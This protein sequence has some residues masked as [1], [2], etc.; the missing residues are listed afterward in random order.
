[1]GKVV[2][3]INGD[4]TITMLEGKNTDFIPG[5]DG[6]AYYPS[7]FNALVNEIN[8]AF[9]FPVI[10]FMLR[11][12]T[13]R[14]KHYLQMNYV[15]NDPDKAAEIEQ[16]SL[17]TLGKY[18]TNFHAIDIRFWPYFEHDYTRKFKIIGE[19]DGLA[20]VVGGYH[21]RTAAS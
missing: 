16:A 10:H 14:N 9:G 8:K 18:F 13:L 17:E 2:T 4:Q 15:V 11:H 6:Y 5:A 20:E 19:G 12:Q 21:Q 7:F 1:M 3:D